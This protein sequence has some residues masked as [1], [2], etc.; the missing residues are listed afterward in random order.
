[1]AGMW[2]QKPNPIQKECAFCGN[3]FIAFSG[4][5]KY[6]PEH[7]D[8]ETRINANRRS[9]NP[10]KVLFNMVRKIDKYNREHGTHL[11]YGKYINLVEGK[12]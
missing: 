10:N 7:R 2:K 6:C 8:P 9:E 4:Q 11:S 5:A 3:I 12:Q 1:M